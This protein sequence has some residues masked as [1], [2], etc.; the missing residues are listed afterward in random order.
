MRFL[1]SKGTGTAI[2]GENSILSDIMLITS[3]RDVR[4]E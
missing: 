2:A 3:D 1:T 4:Y